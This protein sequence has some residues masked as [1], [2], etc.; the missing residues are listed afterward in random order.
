MTAFLI[1]PAHR[2]DA[3]GIARVHVDSWR[4]TYKGI[5]PDTI[6]DNLSYETRTRQWYIGLSNPNRTIFDYVATDPSDQIVGFVN[7]G[8]ERSGDPEYK[9]ELY[10]IYLL[11][12]VQGQGLGRRLML[13]LVERLVQE[14]Y[15]NMLLWVLAANPARKFCQLPPVRDRRLVFTSGLHR[16][17]AYLCRRAALASLSD[18]S[19]MSDKHP[20]LIQSCRIRSVL[21]V[22]LRAPIR[23]ACN[24]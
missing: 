15:T 6:L 24:V 19:G 22:T 23:S 21:M 13:T 20:V 14:R 2:D 1:R 16:N 17:S 4:T 7:G 5:V 9:G 8:T 10:A 11:K 18:A 12:E 3:A